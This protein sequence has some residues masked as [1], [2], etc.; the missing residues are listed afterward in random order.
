MASNYYSRKDISLR[1]GGDRQSFLP[2]V[3]GK[4]VAICLDPSHNAWKQEKAILVGTGKMRELSAEYLVNQSGAVP[5]YI[6]ESPKKW[7]SIG[8]WRVIRQSRG[9]AELKRLEQIRKYPHN[10]PLKRAI[11][12]AKARKDRTG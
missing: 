12:M 4:V 9:A 2:H 8:L 10:T 1:H 7:K 3:D 5:V 6:K 11:W